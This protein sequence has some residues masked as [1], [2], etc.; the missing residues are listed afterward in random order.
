[1]N[2]RKGFSLVELLAALAIFLILGLAI[3]QI[4][5]AVNRV[6]NFSNRAIDATSQSRLAFDRIGLD[7]SALVKR[8]DVD[9]IAQNVSS[10]TSNLLCISSVTSAGLSTNNRGISVV[11]Y[12]IAPHAD[13]Q[14]RPCLLRAG[15]PISSGT[16]GFF[17]LQSNGLPVQLTDTSVASFVPSI[18][19]FDVLAPGVIRLVIGFQLYPDN[20]SVKLVSG[21]TVA[22]SQGQVVY[23]PPIKSLTPSGGGNAVNYI[24]LS[25]VSSIVVGLA[26]IDLKSLQL[27]NST[28]VSD[29]AKTFTL[30]ADGS[31]PVATWAPIANKAYS[32]PS[33]IPL[34]A[35]QAVHVFERSFSITPYMTSGL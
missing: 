20:K 27:L 31:L 32:M 2:F 15:K 29:L 23:S 34:P 1:M 24:D 28:Q 21:T 33:S 4:T 25:R 22:K 30:P 18:T 26:T 7:M 35:R 14:G 8:T 10:G 3:M 17:G 13:N 5:T 16:A 12:E 6:T 19:D 11:S 9:F